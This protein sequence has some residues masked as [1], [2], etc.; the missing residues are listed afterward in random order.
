MLTCLAVSSAHV[1]PCRVH[2]LFLTVQSNKDDDNW[3]RLEEVD[4]TSDAGGMAN[5]KR[6]KRYRKVRVVSS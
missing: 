1:M 5:Y 6:G 3:D 2:S 4:H